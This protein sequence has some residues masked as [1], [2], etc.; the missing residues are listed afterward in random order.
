MVSDYLLTPFLTVVLV[1]VTDV[2]RLRTKEIDAELK[3][4]DQIVRTTLVMYCLLAQAAVVPVAK[5]HF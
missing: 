3:E 4:A 2:R 5:L 1:R